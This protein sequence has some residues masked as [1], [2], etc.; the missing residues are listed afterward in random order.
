MWHR[1]KGGLKAAEELSRYKN[2]PWSDLQLYVFNNEVHFREPDMGQV[3]AVKSGQYVNLPL[4]P[5]I[6][7]V[8]EKSNLLRERA[9]S[10]RCLGDCRNHN[11]D[12]RDRELQQGGLLACADRR[13]VSH[14]DHGEVEARS[15]V[16][17]LLLDQNVADPVAAMFRE[18]G[19]TVHLV[20]DILPANSDHAGSASPA[21]SDQSVWRQA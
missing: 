17:C 4:R 15:P 19:H 10:E 13:R 21:Q 18:F 8:A 20:R 1:P 7:E 12:P 6:E 2:S 5:I 9:T 14:S 11:S 3:R 16:M